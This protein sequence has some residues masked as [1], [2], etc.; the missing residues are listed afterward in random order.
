MGGR[1]QGGQRQGGRGR[2]G[3]FGRLGRFFQD[4]GSGQDQES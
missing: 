2:R 1:G 3:F 4:G